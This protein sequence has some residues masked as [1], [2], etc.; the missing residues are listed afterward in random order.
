MLTKFFKQ[1]FAKGLITRYM[2]LVLILFFCTG[3]LLMTGIHQFQ[4]IE[5]EVQNFREFEAA[6]YNQFVYPSNYGDYGLRLHFSHIPLMAF[7][8]IPPI[9]DYLTTFI[10][11]SERMRINRPFKGK[12]TFRGEGI[13]NYTGFILFF[14]TLLALLFGFAGTYNQTWSIFIDSVFTFK[15]ILYLA[16]SRVLTVFIICLALALEGIVIF[17][18]AGVAMYTYGIL[19]FFFVAFLMFLCFLFF[20]LAVGCLRNRITSISAI[21]IFWFALSVLFPSFLNLLTYNRANKIKSSY[22]LELTKLK[23]FTEYEKSSLKKEGLFDDSKRGTNIETQMFLKFWDNGFK[24][25]MRT[26]RDLLNEMK[27]NISFNQFLS[28][29]CPTTNFNSV[30]NELS[31]R[32]YLNLQAFNEYSQVMK[33]DFI[34]YIADNHIMS[35]NKSFPPFINA[36]GN[37]FAATSK[38]PVNYG[39][40]IVIMLFWLIMTIFFFCFSFYRCLN[41]KSVS[42]RSINPVADEK[43]FIK[44]L[45]TQDKL[46]IIRLV[47]RCRFEGLPFVSVPAPADIPGSLRVKD[48][49]SLFS[50][51]VAAAFVKIKNARC[52]DLTQGQKSRILLTIICS[53]DAE[54][55][56]FNN[57]AAELSDKAKE[58]FKETLN[59]LKKGRIIYNFT[60]S[61]GIGDLSLQ[62]DK[63][64]KDE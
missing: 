12:S 19:S 36:S 25:L 7:S 31:G 6:K 23:L 47:C 40:G 58:R 63:P 21:I 27:E 62:L 22:Q 1:E 3:Y 61:V 37:V 30:A 59:E 54:I 53:L 17:Y 35:K 28:S 44:N 48:L 10:D 26:E 41:I 32:G 39:F 20:G 60:R 52:R 46:K 4:F 57:F 8:N 14:G 11:A 49:Y 16:L 13:F 45:I 29:L 5:T 56:I 9:P 64:N 43:G 2:V 50:R 33:K 18:L 24:V 51:P 34:W 38:T 55:F 15:I 42:E